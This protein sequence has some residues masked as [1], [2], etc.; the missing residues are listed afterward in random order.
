MVHHHNLRHTYGSKMD[1]NTSYV[2]VH[3]TSFVT[4]LGEFK[5]F[6]YILCYGSSEI[7]RF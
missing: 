5:I 7:A 6:K 1:L 2:M 3:P 4:N